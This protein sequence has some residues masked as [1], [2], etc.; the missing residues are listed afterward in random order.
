MR[1]R[2]KVIMKRCK[3]P[4]DMEQRTMEQPFKRAEALAEE[5]VE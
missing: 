5:S 1:G 3:Y 4:P 2:I